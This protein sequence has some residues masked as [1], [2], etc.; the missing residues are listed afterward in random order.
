MRI[1]TLEFKLFAK[2]IDL[3]LRTIQLGLSEVLFFRLR[4][5]KLKVELMV[6]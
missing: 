2:T 1:K 3:K 4:L 5:N 6:E